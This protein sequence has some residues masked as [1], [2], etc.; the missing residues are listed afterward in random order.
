MENE[1]ELELGYYGAVLR[2]RWWIVAATAL[3]FAALVFLVLP[4]QQTTYE[5]SATMLL[6]ADVL[7][8]SSNNKSDV[9]EETEAGIVSST[10]VAESSLAA[11]QAEGFK[12]DGW[13]GEDFLDALTVRPGDDTQLLDL[14]FEGPT[15]EFARSGVAAAANEYQNFKILSATEQRDRLVGNNESQLESVQSRLDG[16]IESVANAPAGSAKLIIAQT[17]LAQY[18]REAIDLRTEINRLQTLDMSPGQVIGKPTVPEA[19][20]SG[21]NRFL[22]LGLALLAGAL[23]GTAIAMLIDRIDRRVRNV[24][25]IEA[26]LAGPVVGEIPRITEDNPSVITAVRAETEGANAFRRLAT[27][28]LARDR[29]VG[30]ILITSAND[31]EGRTL[32]AINTAIALSQA[33]VPVLLMSADR[34]NPAIDRIFGLTG[35]P[36]IEGYLRSPGTQSDATALLQS[37]ADILGVRVLPSGAGSGVAQPMSSRSI[38]TVLDVAQ[39]R[40]ALVVIDAPPALSHPDGLALAALVDA[41]YVVVAPGRTS[42]DELTDLRIQ[43]RRIGSDV[44]GAVVNRFNRWDLRADNDQ[45]IPGIVVKAPTAAVPQAD[46]PT[47]PA[48]ARAEIAPAAPEAAPVEPTP[49]TTAP[50]V[51]QPVPAMAAPVLE[52]APNVAPAAA[53]RPSQVPGQAVVEAPAPPVSQA[54]PVTPV[55]VRPAPPTP[56]PTAAGEDTGW[57]FDYR[58]EGDSKDRA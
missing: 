44:A 56:Q 2:R 26:D 36:G 54:P 12:V 52:S 33:G 15:A 17:N 30:S 7:N 38:E 4:A 1:E 14:S 55:P 10:P 5:S 50:A 39:S 34:K 49:E 35:H 41:T 53:P 46:A 11:L 16:A 32:T 51:A 21:I 48:M 57:D 18:E 42:R 29:Q 28:I 37:S 47:A 19:V 20:T 9:N 45:V 58:P 13:T 43:L 40:G 22:G 27:A 8:T 25:E 3:L 24:E 31:E 6:R 23:A